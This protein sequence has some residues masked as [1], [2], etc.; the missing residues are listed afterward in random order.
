MAPDRQQRVP[1]VAGWQDSYRNGCK[2]SAVTGNDR[3]I[4]ETL[5]KKASPVSERVG[6]QLVLARLT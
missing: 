6:G 2:L 4:G 1:L 3:F 5:V